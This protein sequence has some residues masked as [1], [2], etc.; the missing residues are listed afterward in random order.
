MQQ[1]LFDPLQMTRSSMIWQDRF[2]SDYANGYDDQGRLL[3][4]QKR[5][6][7][8]GAGSM[9][10]TPADFARFLQTAAEGK[11]LRRDVWE[12]MLSPQILIPGISSRPSATKRL[13]KMTPSAS[14]TGWLGACTG[15]LTAKLFSRKATTTDGATMLCALKNRGSAS[16][17]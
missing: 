7:A 14:A 5:K 15:H 3:G 6:R 10:T 13:P 12:Q 9:L 17:S 1:R 8:D 11:L 16:L 2:E 4:P